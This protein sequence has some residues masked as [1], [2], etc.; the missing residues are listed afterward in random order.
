MALDDSSEIVLLAPICGALNSPVPCLGT[1]GL[2]AVLEDCSVFVIGWVM[3]FGIVQKG[4]TRRLFGLLWSSTF[5]GLAGFREG[6]SGT[7]VR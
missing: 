1:C 5:I 6:I 7:R 3:M 2:G 4:R